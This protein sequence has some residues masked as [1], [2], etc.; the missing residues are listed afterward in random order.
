MGIPFVPSLVQIWFKI[1]DTELICS[2]ISIFKI[3]TSTYSVKLGH[4]IYS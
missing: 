3:I 2:N 4:I 1:E